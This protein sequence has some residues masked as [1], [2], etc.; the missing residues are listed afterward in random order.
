MNSRTLKYHHLLEGKGGKRAETLYT[1]SSTYLA[2]FESDWGEIH[3]HQNFILEVSACI[4]TAPRGRGHGGH[5]EAGENSLQT[6]TRSSPWIH[7]ISLRLSGWFCHLKMLSSMLLF[8][9]TILWKAH[10]PTIYPKVYCISEVGQLGQL[11]RQRLK[12]R[13]HTTHGHPEMDGA[14]WGRWERSSCCKARIHR[15]QSPLQ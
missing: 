3:T 8:G 14:R 5:Q 9:N 7:C 6:L 2:M 4:S 11:S 13:Y 10:L 12:L 15:R 1:F